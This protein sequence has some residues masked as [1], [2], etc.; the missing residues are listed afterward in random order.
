MTGPD[1]RTCLACRKELPLDCYYASKTNKTGRTPT[2]KECIKARS[3]Q[4]K[5]E[6]RE[7]AVANDARWQRENKER[8]QAKGNRWRARHPYRAFF[9][10]K[11]RHSNSRSPGGRVTAKQLAARWEYYGGRC[12]VCKAE[13]TEIDHVKPMAWGGSGWPA[14]LRPICQPCNIKKS[15]RWGGITFPSRPRPVCGTRLGYRRHQR[16]REPICEPCRVAN[17]LHR[18]QLRRAS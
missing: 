3:K 15:S 10:D 7:R 13:A 17:R 18:A 8:V 12:W 6:N 5:R 9:V 1:T 16:R 4:W 11:A 14:N 2:C